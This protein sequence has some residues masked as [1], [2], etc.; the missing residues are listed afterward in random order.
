M[1][2]N[3]YFFLVLLSYEILCKWL[4]SISEEYVVLMAFQIETML[5]L[6]VRFD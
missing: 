4:F 6:R 5:H 1:V 3:S 2:C